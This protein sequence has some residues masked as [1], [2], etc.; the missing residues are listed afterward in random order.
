[1]YSRFEKNKIN[2]DDNNNNNIQ[3]TLFLKALNQ[4]WPQYSPEVI[5]D[6]YML[7]VMIYVRRVIEVKMLEW[8]RFSSCS[9]TI[10]MKACFLFF[11]LSCG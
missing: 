2:N 8:G 10:D 7:Y 1:M 3:E 11:H 5:C 4:A 6:V 9:F